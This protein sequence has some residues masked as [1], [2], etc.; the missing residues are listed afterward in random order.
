MISIN[1]RNIAEDVVRLAR[2][3]GYVTPREVRDELTS[4]GLADALW[5]EVLAQTSPLLTRRAGRFYYPATVS[6]PVR[7]AQTHQEEIRRAVRLLIRQH[8]AASSQE[9][10]RCQDRLDFIQPVKVRTEDN[11]E[12]TLL[13][14]DLSSSGIRLVGTRSLLGQKVRVSF[15]PVAEGP[16]CHF[17]VRIL[18]TLRRGR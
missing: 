11:R 3:Q 7:Q 15:P 4:S 13:S 2:R 18:W 16:P 14:R 17:V 9:E 10:R 5:K 6:D 8:K 12:F 1:L